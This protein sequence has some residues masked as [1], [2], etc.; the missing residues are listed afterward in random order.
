MTPVQSWRFTTHLFPAL[1]HLEGN[2]ATYSPAEG[3]QVNQNHTL[4]SERVRWCGTRVI[5]A[6]L[7]ARRE[8]FL[9]PQSGNELLGSCGLEQVA[10][11]AKQIISQWISQ[12]RTFDLISGPAPSLVAHSMAKPSR[13]PQLPSRIIGNVGLG[14][15]VFWLVSF[16]WP[17]CGHH[18]VAM[19]ILRLQQH[20][21][22][23]SPGSWPS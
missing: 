23:G 15:L 4:T 21:A 14:S 8:H 12:N 13:Q 7:S 2:T 9:S 11:A 22:D 1:S 5:A 19:D 16:I 6:T 20:L 17:V 10:K 3:T 18:G